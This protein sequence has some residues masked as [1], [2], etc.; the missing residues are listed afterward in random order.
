MIWGY[1]PGG[2]RQFSIAKIADGITDL[3][4]G[5]TFELTEVVEHLVE[6]VRC[7]RTQ[8]QTVIRATIAEPS[9]SLLSACLFTVRN[10]NSI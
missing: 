4:F 7:L 9:V 8:Q 1:L 10:S 5:R 3:R 2:G 6:L